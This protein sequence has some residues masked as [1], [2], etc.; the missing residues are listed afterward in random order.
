[1]GAKEIRQREGEHWDFWNSKDRTL[2]KEDGDCYWIISKWN[3]KN[4]WG[5]EKWD[6][7]KYRGMTR[8]M[9]DYSKDKPRPNIL[10]IKLGLDAPRNT[11]KWYARSNLKFDAESGAWC[12]KEGIRHEHAVV[13]GLHVR[14]FPRADA[15]VLG[16]RE[17]GLTR[18][19]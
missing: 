19:Y 16:A 12:Y 5:I 3:S 14:N 2:T 17:A 1:M 15:E 13:P 6:K 4:C 10:Y 9:V 18:K 8:S 11:D 7:T